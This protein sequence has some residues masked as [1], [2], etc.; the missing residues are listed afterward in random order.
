MDSDINTP[1]PTSDAHV[2]E[3]PITE[4][5]DD[6]RGNDNLTDPNKVEDGLVHGD[7][8][9]EE[10][11]VLDDFIKN[12]FGDTEETFMTSVKLIDDSGR[13]EGV[14]KKPLTQEEEDLG[15]YE[16]PDDDGNVTDTEQ[17]LIAEKQRQDEEE[18]RRRKEDEAKMQAEI[19]AAKLAIVKAEDDKRMQKQREAEMEAERVLGELV[20]HL[21]P[22]RT[23]I[24][25]RVVLSKDNIRTWSDPKFLQGLSLKEI[26]WKTQKLDQPVTTSMA[27]QIEQSM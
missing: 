10:E 15:I 19:T 8:E 20:K 11:N 24:T 1:L 25:P 3:I 14:G 6:G 16:D 13:G 5:T 17:E 22:E 21:P 9:H 27:T 18:E 4:N 12:E 7:Q 23:V 26:Y 2:I